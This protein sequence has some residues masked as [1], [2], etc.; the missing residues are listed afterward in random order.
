MVVQGFLES[1]GRRKCG[2]GY[3]GAQPDS[4]GFAVTHANDNYDHPAHSR[5]KLHVLFV[6]RVYSLEACRS[7]FNSISALSLNARFTIFPLGVLG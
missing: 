6:C 2:G 7:L 1:Q 3:I 5:G 4:G